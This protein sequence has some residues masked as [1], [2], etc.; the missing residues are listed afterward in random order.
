M[1]RYFASRRILL[2]L[3]LIAAGLLIAGLA[4][5]IA[6]QQREARP[7]APLSRSHHHDSPSAAKPLPGQITHYKVAPLL[8]KYIELPSINVPQT[9][10][11]NLGVRNNGEIATPNNIYDAGWYNGSAKPSQDG[12]AFIYGHVSSWQ[13]K[14]IFYNLKK[15][16]PGNK[17]FI[18]LGNDTKLTYEV[19]RIQ[20]YQHDQ[21][22]MGA[23][24]SPVN[25]GQTGLN[26]MTCTGPLIKGT[27]EFSQRLVVFTRLISN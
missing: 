22:D 18:T 8:P 1:G 25:N 10:I 26:L 6:I 20:V 2:A 14:G 16:R 19:A 5:F 3:S 12:A 13:A 15:M 27:G 17:L 9:R 11:V 21:V 7:L 4:L 23:V 24:L